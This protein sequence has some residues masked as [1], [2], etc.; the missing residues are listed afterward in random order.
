MS[1]EEPDNLDDLLEAWEVQEANLDVNDLQAVTAST[2]AP[3][4]NVSIADWK[5][6]FDKAL[7]GAMRQLV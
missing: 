3:Q 6:Q 1:S 7:K 5:K 2:A 4:L